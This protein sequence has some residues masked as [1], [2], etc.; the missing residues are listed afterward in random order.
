[1]NEEMPVIKNDIPILEFDTDPNAVIMPEHEQLG[2]HLPEK[3]VYAFLGS[4]IDKYAQSHEA[5]IV[6][7]FVSETRNYPVYVLEFKGEEICMVQ[8]PVGASASA[9]ILDWLISY[10]VKEVISAGCCGALTELEEN[11][12]LIPK[13]ALRDEGT[14][15]HYLPPARFIDIDWTARTAIE[16]TLQEYGHSYREVI[17][18]TT[19]GF[20]RETKAMVAYRRKEGCEAVEMECSALA[21]CASMRGIIWGELLFTADSLADV[22]NYDERG[23]GRDSFDVA[24]ILCLEAAIKIE[25]E[26]SI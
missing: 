22:E 21:S 11:T 2:M 6:S 20:Y 17:T 3:C 19:D 1:V 7:W 8:A 12:F 5:N 23:W 14:S 16:K 18:W 24:L 4:A 9:Q 15:Y 13:K 25:K 26:Q 10:G